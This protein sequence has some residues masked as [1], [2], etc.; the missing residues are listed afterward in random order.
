MASQKLYISDVTK[1]DRMIG[2]RT[3]VTA[4][5]I[6]GLS[7]LSVVPALADPGDIIFAR[8]QDADSLDMARVSSTISFQVM[9][10]IYEPLLNLDASGHIVGGLASRYTASPDNMTFTFTIR[11]NVKCQDGTTFNAAAAKWNIDRTINP[12]T[13]SPN[14]SSYGDITGTSVSGDTLTIKLG[15][16]YSP[17]PTFLASAQA[18]M[19]C[20]TT[21]QGSNVTPVGTGPWKF[22]QWIRNDRIVLARNP[23]YVNDDPLVSNPG[24]PYATRLIFRVI[25]EGPARMAALQTGEVTFAEPSLEDASDLASNKGYTVYTGAGRTGQLAYLGFT[26]KIPP[27][28]DVRVRRAIGYAVDRNAMVD[29]GFNDLVQSSTCPVAP[30]LLGY[31]PKQC[32]AWATSYNVAKAKDLLKQA[33]YSRAHPLDLTLSVSPLQGWDE[34]DVVMQQELKAIGVNVKIEQR[35]FASWVDYMSVKNRQT[36]GVP[37]I[38]TMGMS[39]VDPDYLVFLWQPPGYAGQGVDDPVLAK[40]LVDQRALSGSARL[41]KIL[42]IQKFLLTNAYEVPLFSPGWFWLAASKSDVKGFVQGYTVMPIF[43]DVKLP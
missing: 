10:Q 15:K 28:N 29:I 40:L 19:M 18:L 21:I 27:L 3:L 31:D 7:S 22:V 38:W 6:A 35:Q 13:G 12:K 4:C 43:N 32:A 39:G 34:S 11:P 25:P 37:A 20:P 24:P 9:S 14:A 17:L 1:D 26:A 8:S 23:D 5:L 41:A 2:R 30:G 33:G 36:T 42:D 16:P